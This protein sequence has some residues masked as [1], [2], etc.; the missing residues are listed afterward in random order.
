[1]TASTIPEPRQ[2]YLDTRA[3]FDGVAEAYKGP[4]GNNRLVQ[5]MR[6]M[7]WREVCRVAAPGTRLLDLGC[8]TGHDAVYFARQDYSVTAIDWSSGMVAQTRRNADAAGLGE[9]VRTA[10]LGIQELDR[11][12]EK[13]FGCIYSDLGALNC[14]NDL[15]AVADWSANILQPGGALVFSVIGRYCPW[16]LAYYSLRGNFSRMRV[17]FARG[18][19]PVG[20]NGGKVWTQYYSPAEF[21]RPFSASF[22]WRRCRALS[23]FAP[24]PYLLAGF[25]RHPRLLGALGWLDNQLGGLP[26]LNRAGDHFLLVMTRQ[27]GRT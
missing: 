18:E 3:A 5:Q 20:L 6:V 10:H 24:P 17:R 12:R 26:L 1:M 15:A 25:E 7:L 8:G 14:V 27:E 11:I 4:L 2:R 9:R 21:F 13:G 22:A 23:L 16:E 19:V